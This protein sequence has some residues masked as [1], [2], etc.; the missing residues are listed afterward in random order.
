VPRSAPSGRGTWESAHH[1]RPAPPNSNFANC[2]RSRCRLSL[3]ESRAA[4]AE[5]KA[6]IHRPKNRASAKPISILH[7]PSSILRLPSSDF[8]PPCVPPESEMPNPESRIP[9]PLF[10]PLSI[11]SPNSHFDNSRFLQIS[12]FAQSGKAKKIWTGHSENMGP[13]PSARIA[14]RPADCRSVSPSL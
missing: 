2:Q 3:R 5:R 6:T 12:R 11:V 7:P 8:H 10:P 9:N 13:S 4:F 1:C 14:A